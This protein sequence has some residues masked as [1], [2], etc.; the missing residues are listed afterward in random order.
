MAKRNNKPTEQ[1][2]QLELNSLVLQDVKIELPK[3]IKFNQFE[4]IDWV[5]Y[6]LGLIAFVEDSNPL[7]YTNIGECNVLVGDCIINGKSIN[8]Q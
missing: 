8:E 5:N 3:H 6:T 1:P 2:E 4:L 7:F